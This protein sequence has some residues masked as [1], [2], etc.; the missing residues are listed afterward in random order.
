L[1]VISD[2]EQQEDTY[3]RPELPE[4]YPAFVE[5]SINLPVRD[6]VCMVQRIYRDLA[7]DATYCIEHG[8]VADIELRA[9]ID[10][11]DTTTF[12]D[13]QTTFVR[14]IDYKT[15]GVTSKG[16]IED[17]AAFQ[18]PIYMLMAL[19]AFE[20]AYPLMA[21]FARLK[22]ITKSGRYSH[23][24]ELLFTDVKHQRITIGK[25][26]NLLA[27]SMEHAVA[28]LRSIK[29]GVFTV[30]PRDLESSCRRCPYRTLCRRDVARL[31][32]G[33]VW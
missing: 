16:D 11:I 33:R 12:G 25:H 17:G 29:R 27:V 3:K 5:Y 6:L 9:R 13:E 20:K 26:F 4:L 14:V 19:S 22:E 23:G 1:E 18:L 28:A 30:K 7:E 31:R 15:G 24:S 8:D 10:R 2:A 32:E 21:Y